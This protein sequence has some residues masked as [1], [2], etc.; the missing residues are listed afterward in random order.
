MSCLLRTRIQGGGVHQ[1]DCYNYGR[2]QR[3]RKQVHYFVG[4]YGDAH[5][6]SYIETRSVSSALIHTF[7]LRLTKHILSKLTLRLIQPALETNSPSCIKD[8][9]SILLLT[10]ADSQRNTPNGK[11]SFT[12]SYCFPNNTQPFPLNPFSECIL[13]MP[14]ACYMHRSFN[15]PFVPVTGRIKVMKHTVIYFSSFSFH[16]FS[17]VTC[18]KL[19]LSVVSCEDNK[20]CY[21][22]IKQVKLY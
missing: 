6:E 14:S 7:P 21:I 16:S 10:F 12:V 2:R 17:S 1:T 22:L 5:I 15:L 4:L 18:R 13:Q 9:H 8:R 11:V 3:E 20:I 19:P